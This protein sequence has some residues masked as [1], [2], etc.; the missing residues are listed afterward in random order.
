MMNMKWMRS[1]STLSLAAVLTLGILPGAHNAEAA[2][3]DSEMVSFGPGLSVNVVDALITEIDKAQTS[4]DGAFYEVRYQPFV[5]AL[6]RAKNRGVAIRIQTDTDYINNTFTQQ[7]ISAGISVKGDNRSAIMHDKY[8]IID[9]KKVWMGSANTTDTDNANNYDNT[10]LWES[11]DLAKIYKTDFEEMFVSNQFTKTA[12]PST[13][14]LQKTTVVTASRNIPVE[15]Y[16]AP[17]D[18]PIQALIDVINNAKYS[19]YFDYFS[20]TDDNVRA[21]LINAKNR[22]VKVEGLFDY[23]QYASNGPYGEL[24]YL[25]QAGIPVSIADVPYGGKMHNKV[26]IADK[27]YTNGTVVTGSFNAS[28]NANDSNSENLMVIHDNQTAEQY[29]NEFLRIRGEY[30]RGTVSI[31]QASAPA[32]SIQT[33]KVT[34][35]APSTYPISKTSIMAPPKW[36]DPSAS[37]VT[38]VKSDGTDVSSQLTFSGNNVYLD[39]A[40]LKGNQ[41]VTF[42]FTDWTAPSILGD[43]SW[44][45]ESIASSAAD[46]YDF[47]PVN[48]QAATLAVQ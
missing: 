41:S 37:T 43:Y 42:S 24:A 12:S 15:V 14:E 19:V 11:A 27:G 21:A 5:D 8:A 18:N 4:I 23:S 31:N 9:G 26:L 3:T 22:G 6:I 34:L 33:I 7:L 1:I 2:G 30:G 45:T 48:Y 47:L 38:A 46:Q 29:Y 20:F 32:S 39:T 44:Y 25:A 35:R 17:D 16:F 13:P 10:I 40:N 28:A 36:P